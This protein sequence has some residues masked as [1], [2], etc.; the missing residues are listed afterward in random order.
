[1]FQVVPEVTS[2]L[3][4]ID[5]GKIVLLKP[6]DKYSLRNISLFVSSFDDRT[7]D[8]LLGLINDLREITP[9]GKTH[10]REITAPSKTHEMDWSEEI[11]EEH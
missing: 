11:R 9:S 1:M 4:A 6:V 5:I 2:E 8:Q 3:G 7:L 10:G